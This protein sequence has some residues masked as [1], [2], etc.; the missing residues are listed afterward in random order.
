MATS[1]IARMFLW[2]N[3]IL[4][5]LPRFNDIRICVGKFDRVI[6]VRS[7]STTPNCGGVMWRH[8]RVA[9]YPVTMGKTMNIERCHRHPI[10][11]KWPISFKKMNQ[12]SQTGDLKDSKTIRRI[13]EG[14]Q[15]Q[16]H[17]DAIAIEILFQYVSTV[18]W[19]HLLMQYRPFLRHR[20]TTVSTSS[21][22]VKLFVMSQVTA[23]RHESSQNWH[24]ATICLY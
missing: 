20:R 2:Y 11:R 17:K 1:Q 9:T 10:R 23:S 3:S 13:I 6:A 24:G 14:Q 21:S 18:H 15:L 5:F 7:N 19:Q 22:Y 8:G 16:W 12:R 4:H